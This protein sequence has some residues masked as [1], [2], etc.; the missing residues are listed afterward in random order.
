MR[1]DLKL[2]FDSIAKGLQNST[3]F[4]VIREFTQMDMMSLREKLGLEA[5]SE[6]PTD[7]R[8]VYNSTR[9]L[10][11]TE[12]ITDENLLELVANLPKWLGFSLRL[13]EAGISG[14]AIIRSAK[15]S[16]I[17][18]LWLMAIPKTIISPLTVPE[19]FEEQG[20]YVFMRNLLESE[21]S[22]QWI[23]LRLNEILQ[24]KGISSATVDFNNLTI[25]YDMENV[26][27]QNRVPHLLA[28]NMMLATG[29]PVDLDKALALK[30]SWLPTEVTSYIQTMH[31]MRVL[32]G[33]IKGTSGNKPFEW[34][35]VGNSKS[36]NQLLS[37]LQHLRVHSANMR[38]CTMCLKPL[39]DTT[40]QMTE[41]DFYAFLIDE[42]VSQYADELR[43]R[44]GKGK[45][46]QLLNFI[47]FLQTK[48][49]TMAEQIHSAD[50]KAKSLVKQLKQIKR[51]VS[52][53]AE[54]YKSPERIYRDKL[55]V[56]ETKLKVL[57]KSGTLDYNF[58]KEVQPVFSAAVDI[59]HKNRSRLQDDT[60]DFME[61]LCFETS[62]R[63]LECLDLANLLNDLPWVSR[64]ISEEAT[65]AYI[66]RG[67]DDLDASR[68]RIERI[69]A[70]YLGGLTYLVLQ[71]QP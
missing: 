51:S 26:I 30:D 69:A 37:D 8:G 71:N 12:A 10:I 36:C 43:S 24:S 15:V 18:S 34:P 39:D 4:S 60:D 32:R 31:T 46:R 64:F 3:Y 2:S 20:L 68:R 53:G 62:F 38:S 33:H 6:M 28:I 27:A 40:T 16:T 9:K 7:P 55:G 63:L 66:V 50:D 19:E 56:L 13:S 59:I 47:E 45:N 35:M 58:G 41:V 23:G 17:T 49:E 5:D 61:A 67:V 21:T 25:G 48:K 54:P 14:E 44:R 52:S 22:R 70:A 42:L 1:D 57:R 65:R 11:L 29:L